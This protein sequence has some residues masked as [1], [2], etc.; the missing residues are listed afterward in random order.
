MKITLIA[1]M[2]KHQV[3]GHHNQ[4]P[5]HLPKDLAH[6]KARTVNKAIVM[7]RKTFESMGKPLPGRRNI[8]LTR[9]AD[10]KA[11]GVEVFSNLDALLDQVNVDELMVIG[12]AEIYQLFMPLSTQM[13]LT[14]IDADISGDAFF[15][16]WRVEEWE[17]VFQEN[18]AKDAQNPFDMTFIDF[19]R[20]FSGL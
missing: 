6:F 20:I 1:A 10:F 11:S 2:A 17:I 12:G 18:H 16:A 13:N 19:K 4:L 9:Q 3:I 7:G 5:W 14:L 15:P 8:V